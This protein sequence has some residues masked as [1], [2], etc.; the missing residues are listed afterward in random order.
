MV[1]TAAQYTADIVLFFTVGIFLTSYGYR[2]GLIGAYH[3]H[4]AHSGAEL[5]LVAWVGL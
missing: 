4:R 3:P 5:A 1:S 2:C